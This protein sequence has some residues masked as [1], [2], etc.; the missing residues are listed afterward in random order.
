MCSV[1]D[2]EIK[3]ES[4]C[5]FREE[6]NC[7]ACNHYKNKR[8]KKE[9]KDV[10]ISMEK[11]EMK[12][13]ET[14]IKAI[15]NNEYCAEKNTKSRLVCSKRP[16]CAIVS[17]TLIIMLAI[18]TFLLWPRIP[19]VRIDGA[20]LLSP[21][22]TTETHH[23]MTSDI[24]Y[25]TSWLLKLTMDNRQNYMTTRFNKMQIMA[26]D[27]LTE[28]IIGKGHEQPVYLPGNTISTVELPLYVNYQA[29]DPFDTTLM[30]LVKACN[31]T[32]SNSSHDALSIHFSLTL[33][34]FM[35]DRLGYTPT[36]TVVP[37]TG[38]FYCP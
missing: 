11:E 17:F 23:G 9:A 26:K 3:E 34:I 12:N 6:K 1:T 7:S 2:D 10:Q 22:K 21:V 15:G 28:R 35:L 4:C 8:K 37:A 29:S 18:A 27:A 13:T 38:G 20:R 5:D 14:P 25:E 16:L 19:L 31:N 24:V 33:Y 32:G 36:I 30:N